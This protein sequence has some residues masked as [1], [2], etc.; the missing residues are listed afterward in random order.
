MNKLNLL[1]CSKVAD[2]K[3]QKEQ[4]KRSKKSFIGRHF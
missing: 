4:Q 3:Q 2:I 1:D